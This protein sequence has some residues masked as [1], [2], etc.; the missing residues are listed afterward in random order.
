M[1]CIVLKPDSVHVAVEVDIK[2]LSSNGTVI[3]N[4]NRITVTN[5]ISLDT[6]KVFQK[7]L[8]FNLV[9]NGDY[10]NYNDTG[11]Y[12]CQA[13]I[14][15][16][17]PGVIENTNMSFFYISVKSKLLLIYLFSNWKYYCE[18][19]INDVTSYVG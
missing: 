19:P 6:D 2:W 17:N 3:V 13:N 18:I 5:V 9:D 11:N 15:S 7:S 14:K 16:G 4:D 12:T 1:T 10:S 8:I